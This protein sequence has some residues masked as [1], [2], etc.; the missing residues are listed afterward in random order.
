MDDSAVSR[1]IRSA[2]DNEQVTALTSFA[3]IIRILLLYYMPYG[4]SFIMSAPKLWAVPRRTAL[5]AARFPTAPAI[6]A[7]IPYQ[8][9]NN[10]NA[11][12][13]T[14]DNEE[15]SKTGQEEE[16]EG[17]MSRRLSQM[18]EDAILDGGRSAQR[19]IEHAGFSEDLK[20]ELEERVKAAS[21]K[22]DNAAAHSILDMPV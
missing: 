6:R 22:S 17:A 20:R 4:H 3:G 16:I 18:T 12:A 14:K 8:H 21:F 13:K 9:R 19:N 5:C 1:A 10:S 11:S 7:R 2:I 15:S